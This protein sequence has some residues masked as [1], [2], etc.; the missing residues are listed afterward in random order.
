[1]TSAPAPSA[2]TPDRRRR[3]PLWAKPLLFVVV[4]LLVVVAAAV[5]L[6][7]GKTLGASETRST[8]VIRSIKGEEQVILVTTGVTDVREERGEGL[9]LG[10]G[11]LKLF[12]LPGSER[13]L[14]VRYEYDAKFGIEGKDVKI[15]R[16]SDDSYR[17]DIPE[18]I[19][20]GF[21]NPKLSVANEKN[22]AFSW[23]TPQID[24]GKVVE[25]ALSDQA[26]T[27]HLEGAQPLLEKQAET[28]YTRI[29]KAVDPSVTLTFTFAPDRRDNP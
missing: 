15:T 24:Q 11:D 1:M 28:F 7:V 14:L 23:T 19:Y 9:Q 10:I 3:A 8:Q 29:V 26:V 13:S 21:D 12:T 22:G 2:S 20:L 4:L 27:E 18:F 17:V 6:T 16:T 5:G 25:K